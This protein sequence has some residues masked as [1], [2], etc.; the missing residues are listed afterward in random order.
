MCRQMNHKNFLL[1]GLAMLGIIL[2]VHTAGALYSFDGVPYPDKLD[3]VAH[4]TFKGGVY[5]SEAR[6]LGFP[7]YE[8]MF[9]LP[10]KITVRWARLYVGVW[11]GTE[12]YEG[13]VQ[14]T[15]NGH[16][17]GK[18]P[19]HGV[20]D[21]NPQVYCS[22]HGVYW[23]FYDVTDTVLPGLNTG[24]A[25]T[26]RGERGNKLDG[27]VYG[28]ILVAI[29][30][31]S[32]A[33]EITYWVADGNPN[34]HGKG[35]AGTIPTL[36]DVASVQF[37]GAINPQNVESAR[38]AVVY[39]AGNPGEPDYLEFNGQLIGGSDVANN[40]DGET[41]GIDLKT[42]VVTPYIQAENSIRFLRGLDL[43]GDGVI[44]VD[45]EGNQEGEYY[46]H[47]VL[48]V[49]VLEHRTIEKTAPD[50]MVELLHANLTEGE[51]LLTAVITNTGR[52]YSDD[53]ELRI[54]VNNSVLYS[55]VIQ[56]D[57]SG[58][59]RVAIPWTAASGTY[60]INAEVDPGNAVQELNEKNNALNAE[61]YVMRNADLSVRILT[62]VA[63][64]A[65]AGSMTIAGGGLLLGILSVFMM[66]PGRC[67]KRRLSTLLVVLCL[68]LLIT[69]C[70]EERVG[71]EHP[72]V[73]ML[74]YSVPV[75]IKNEGEAMARNF[76]LSLF[77]DGEKSVTKEIEKLEG[78]ASVLEQFQIV[79]AE[80]THSIRAVA[81]EKRAVQESRR[82][83]NDAE[84]TFAF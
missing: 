13:W 14:T 81:D 54:L 1:A 20:A 43:N 70:V 83:N 60:M 48:A 71:E 31:S 32:D 68:A 42:F 65:R 55:D 2:A 74:S 77:I 28:I 49:L 6:G 72:R 62:P 84:I 80:G 4:G 3:L 22:G 15:F 17:L 51:N 69:G 41:Y 61:V 67:K 5:I 36:N 78:G 47:P 29:Y 59:R 75:E 63:N 50:F 16:D 73:R 10:D 39:L 38:L 64:E 18:T 53:L 11:G 45:D 24:R 23:T 7:P 79:V 34:L 46:L 52:V 40:A 25:N 27:R 9:E 35:W 57:A 58:I 30:E 66:R 37:N 33:P 44:D 21:T 8:Q 12:R 76:E 82:D 19:L 56:M 26:S